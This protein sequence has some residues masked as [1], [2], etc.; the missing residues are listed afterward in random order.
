MNKKELYS[1]I[2]NSI[3]KDEDLINKD[4]LKNLDEIML[5]YLTATEKLLIESNIKDI[6]KATARIDTIKNYLLFNKGRIL[7]L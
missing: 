4:K 7:I 3:K 6:K 1:K 2:I 5:Y